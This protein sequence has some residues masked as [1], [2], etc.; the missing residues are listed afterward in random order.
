VNRHQLEVIEYGRGCS[1][2]KP[3]R[4]HGTSMTARTRLGK[5]RLE[6]LVEEAIVDAYGES[7]QRVGFLRTLQQY[8]A[9]PFTTE[10]LG[11]PAT[12]ERIDWNDAEEI[13]AVC[14]RQRHR[15][16]IPILD[17]PVPSQRPRGWEWIEAYRYWARG[18]R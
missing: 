1:A 3:P 13:V 8:L 15:Q 7:E 11:Q 12:V 18:W 9:C 5:Q 2:N 6:A 4:K 17:L 16:L 10:I 14:R